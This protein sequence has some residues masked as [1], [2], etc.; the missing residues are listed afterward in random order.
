MTVQSI[1]GCSPKGGSPDVIG[2]PIGCSPTVLVVQSE[3]VH[4][5]VVQ[6]GVDRW[7]GWDWLSQVVGSLRAP[8]VII[9]IRNRSTIY[10]PPCSLGLLDDEKKSLQFP[11][12]RLKVEAT[13]GHL[14]LAKL[15]SSFISC[16]LLTNC[17][18]THRLNPH[19]R[20]SQVARLKLMR[21]TSSHSSF[22]RIN[23]ICRGSK[24]L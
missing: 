23:W 14:S 15:L 16:P 4:Q 11:H 7:T 5:G 21:S 6:T 8:S 10:L 22:W 17:K 2:S 19:P 13:V 12:L 9:K 20:V 24:L 3:I 18:E 1:W